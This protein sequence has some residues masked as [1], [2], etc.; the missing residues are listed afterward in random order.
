MDSNR[1]G[2]VAMKSLSDDPESLCL[3]KECRELESHFNT[4]FTTE[5]LTDADST[6][7]TNIKKSIKKIDKDLRLEMCALKAP[8]IAQVVTDGGSWPKL[9][10]CALHLGSKH[11]KGLQNL[12]RLMAHHGRGSKLCPLCDAPTHPLIEHV[13]TQH[14]SNLSLSSIFDS[15]L[16]T[17]KLLTQLLDCDICFVYKLWKL[18]NDS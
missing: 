7:P 10:D 4:V 5:I 2:I 17:D 6:N 8:F 14:H 13:L 12:T 18:F 9:W 16:S 1:V 11:L 3:V 15:P